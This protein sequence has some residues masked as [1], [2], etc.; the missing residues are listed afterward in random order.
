MVVSFFLF[1]FFVCVMGFVILFLVSG[2][3]KYLDDGRAD[4]F[5]LGCLGG[6]GRELRREGK[7]SGN[8]DG[9]A[10]CD[11]V[12]DLWLCFALSLVGNLVF[13]STDAIMSHSSMSLEI[14]F[15][16]LVIVLRLQ[17][18]SAEL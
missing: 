17:R 15:C 4:G 2:R 8:G 1:L 5:F 13:S 9:C 11:W 16:F 14:Q 18:I 6:E 12:G 10:L 7:R 3:E